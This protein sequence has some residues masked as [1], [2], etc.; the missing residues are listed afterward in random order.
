[1]GQSRFFQGITFLIS[2]SGIVMADNGSFSLMSRSF[3]HTEPIHR[4]HTCDGTDKIPD[5]YWK[6]APAATKTFALIVQDPDAPRATPFIHWLIANLP[7]DATT[8]RGS[9]LEGVNDFG[10][11]G[12]GGPCP[13][14]G[15]P[16]RYFFE[17]YAL[18][19]TLPLSV[20]FTIEELRSAMHNH[21]LAKA[22]LM[23][24]YKRKE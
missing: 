22:E 4:N 6:N 19:T 15:K 7:G 11:Q 10:K 5:L 2:V 24:T 16:H 1:M 9:Y 18:D 13:P 8:I 14:Q 12:Y 23:G 17:L 21:V 3:A 20:G